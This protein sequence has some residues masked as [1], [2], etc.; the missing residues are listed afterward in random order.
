M[1][2]ACLGFWCLILL[3][4]ECS[5]YFFCMLHYGRSL[6]QGSSSLLDPLRWSNN[7]HLVFL[8]KMIKQTHAFTIN[9]V[10]HL[11]IAVLSGI[12]PLQGDRC[13]SVQW[14]VRP[15][16]LYPRVV[17]RQIVSKS[18]RRS[19]WS[20]FKIP[21][22]T[23]LSGGSGAILGILILY[24]VSTSKNKKPLDPSFS[25]LVHDSLLLSLRYSPL[26]FW[27]FHF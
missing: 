5:S 24:Q 11:S 9:L 19:V 26:I 17:E 2:Q 4:D 6:C 20:C 7:I 8:G 21:K 3:Q 15:L 1:V 27:N 14:C 16:R 13:I 10:C 12:G 23:L 25:S 22:I 18:S